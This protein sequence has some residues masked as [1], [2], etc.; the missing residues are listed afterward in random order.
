M[1]KDQLAVLTL[2]EEMER[3]VAVAF[4]AEGRGVM[5][6]QPTGQLI[7]S[8]GGYRI[9][10]SIYSDPDPGKPAQ[11]LLIDAIKKVHESLGDGVKSFVILTSA[12]LK[13]SVAL[14]DP[15]K[16]SRQLC[17]LQLRLSSFQSHSPELPHVDLKQQIICFE[18]IV[19]SF[20][21][22]RFP[23]PVSSV[24]SPLLCKWI[25]SNTN[26]NICPYSYENLNN[27]LK[28]LTFLCKY[29][30][31][32]SR[33]VAE[34][35]MQ[36]GYRV[37]RRAFNLLEEGLRKI[38]L[39]MLGDSDSP[40]NGCFDD[41]DVKTE[42]DRFIVELE[43]KRV[44]SENEKVLLITSAIFSDLTL[45]RLRC[46]NVAVLQAVLP[47][48]LIFI[49]MLMSNLEQE[50]SN[51]MNV[52]A[53]T[54]FGEHYTRLDFPD[55][56]QLFLRAPTV[57][58]AT[59]YACTCQSALKL[60]LVAASHS[61]LPTGT[62]YVMKAGGNFERILQTK[63]IQKCGK[64]MQDPFSCGI[65]SRAELLAWHK[66]S[67]CNKEE[68]DDRKISEEFQNLMTSLSLTD[69]FKNESHSSLSFSTPSKSSCA[70]QIST[71]TDIALVFN[72]IC[73]AF[74]ELDADVKKVI[75][76]TLQAFIRKLTKPSSDK[77]CAIDS[78]GLRLCIL[79][80]S[81]GA[82]VN[83]LRISGIIQT[84]SL[85]PL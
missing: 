79:Q 81:L 41:M 54:E 51:I 67:Q 2:S 1:N 21:S 3:I 28:N 78:V 68:E 52:K 71:C 19:H 17:A 15:V 22:T 59:E 72:N 60:C 56:H 24:L 45:F 76:Q 83:L 13:Y 31:G 69:S 4:G 11:R 18:S 26:S 27:L 39:L 33:P 65:R 23:S 57:E 9:L 38:E 14:G 30:E 16:V 53:V 25:T 84:K 66:Q 63:L 20:F 35:F 29:E 49:S 7:I 5:I 43:G 77:N 6:Q 12:L 36:S 48:E 64:R 55:L 50:S 10:S 61:V 8:R 34:S 85:L 73:D 42:V 44:S 75:I 32:G 82:A 80:H 70:Q 62:P 46:L 37:H 47:D 40:G 58:L 74:S